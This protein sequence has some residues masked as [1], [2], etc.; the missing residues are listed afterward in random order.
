VRL[1]E[2]TFFKHSRSWT[3]WLKPETEV[4]RRSLTLDDDVD[5]KPVGVTSV[6]QPEGALVRLQAEL[7]RAFP[8]CNDLSQISGHGF[9]PHLSVAND[10]RKA[11][12]SC[13]LRTR[14]HEHTH[15]H[16]HASDG[17]T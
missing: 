16:A 13:P 10:F 1:R 5:D 15:A 8:H 3:V 4:P 2:F 7:E 14:T 9:V 12:R 11:V 6:F 17:G